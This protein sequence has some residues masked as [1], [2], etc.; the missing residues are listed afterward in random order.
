MLAA[1]ADTFG[2]VHAE[3]RAG[4]SG[5]RAGAGAGEPQHT[6]RN[7]GQPARSEDEKPFNAWWKT[8]RGVSAGLTTSPM[9]L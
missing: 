4:A 8:V 3:R 2:D 1:G 9:D 6:E 7:R 5:D